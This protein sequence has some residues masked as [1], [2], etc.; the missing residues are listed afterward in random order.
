MN[1]RE[2]LIAA[3]KLIERPENWVKEPHGYMDSRACVCA[4]EAIWR[5]NS[6]AKHE[7]AVNALKDLV[8]D[9]GPMTIINWNDAPERTHAEVLAAFDKAIEAAS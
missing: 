1:T 5:A 9:R 2:V 4:E 7:G 6:G 8:G 3:R